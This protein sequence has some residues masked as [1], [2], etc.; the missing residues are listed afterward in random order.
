MTDLAAED[1]RVQRTKAALVGAFVSLVLDRRYDQIT[2][3]DIV[4]RAGVGRSTFYE[5]YDNKDELLTE[6]LTGPFAVL[7]DMVTGACDPVRIL[8]TIEHFWENRR[9]GNVLFAGPTRQL[10]MRTLAGAIE[11]RLL[12][13][14]RATSPS[15]LPAP[16]ASAYLASAQIGLLSEWLSG[17]T[18]CPSAV[19]ADALQRMAIGALA[20]ETGA[21]QGTP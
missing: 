8:E 21:G 16:L 10:V 13:K 1:R 2:V 7:A 14:S 4:E 6:G 20:W 5:H 19:V 18:S 11:Q 15:E 12:S 17:H 3:A 9:V